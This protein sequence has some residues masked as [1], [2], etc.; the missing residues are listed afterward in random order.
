LGTSRNKMVP[1]VG[2]N[3]Y[4]FHV[5]DTLPKGEVFRAGC[6]VNNTLIQISNKFVPVARRNLVVRARNSWFQRA[7]V[8]HELLPWKKNR[9]PSASFLFSGFGTIGFLAFWMPEMAT[10]GVA[11]VPKLSTIPGLDRSMGMSDR[12]GW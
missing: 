12:S 5:L 7:R 2:G 10:S 1:S 6:F 4:G 3:P 9:A 11:A 8:V